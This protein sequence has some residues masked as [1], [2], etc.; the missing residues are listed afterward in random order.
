MLAM[1]GAQTI[2]QG[3]L[4]VFLPAHSGSQESRRAKVEEVML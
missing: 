3:S 4:R 1:Q 2:K